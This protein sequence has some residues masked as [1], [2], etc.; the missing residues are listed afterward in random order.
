MSDRASVKNSSSIV[1]YRLE[2]PLSDDDDFSDF[3]LK[4]P[5]LST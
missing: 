1:P 2:Q 5:P 4:G 3:P